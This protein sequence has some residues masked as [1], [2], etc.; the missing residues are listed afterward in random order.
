MHIA[1]VRLQ[2]DV[3][4]VDASDVTD[5]SIAR[6]LEVDWGSY[7]AAPMELRRCVVERGYAVRDTLAAYASALN[8]LDDCS[9][10]HLISHVPF[11]HRAEASV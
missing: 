4:A 6:L 3:L 5:E 10:W 2:D 7:T 1:S 11:P 9:P 8:V